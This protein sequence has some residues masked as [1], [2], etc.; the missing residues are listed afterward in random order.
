M[1]LTFLLKGIYVIGLNKDKATQS[2]RR[3]VCAL[4]FTPIIIIIQAFSLSKWGRLRNK[5]P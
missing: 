3:K 5:A 4:F 2:L 1:K